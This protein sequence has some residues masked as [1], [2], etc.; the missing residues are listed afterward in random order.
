MVN[1]AKVKIWGK[2]VGVLMWDKTLGLSSFQYYPSFLKLNIP[3]SPIHLPLSQ[4]Q[5]VYRFQ[6]LRNNS[7]FKG[8]PGLI[9]DSL[10]D[11][12][13]NQ[14]INEWLAKNGRSENSLNPIEQLCFIGKRGMGA[15]EFEPDKLNQEN[16]NFEIELDSLVKVAQKVL[17][18]KNNFQRNWK[19]E[20]EEA[21]I[22]LLKVGTSAGGA[23][24]KAII[25]WNKKTNQIKSGQASTEEG[26]EHWILKL[27]G[28]SDVQ[29]GSS[30][31][32]GRI[33]MAYY[34]MAKAAGINI[35]ESRLLEENGRAHFMTKR[36]DRSEKGEKWHIQT[37]CGMQHF[38]FNEVTRYSYEQLFATMRLLKLSYPE[39]QEQFRRMVFNVLAKNCDDHTK[40]FAFRLKPNQAWELAPAYDVCFSYRP[41][42]NWVSQHALSINGKREH[43]YESD[44]MAL[45]NKINIKSNVAKSIIEEV[46]KAVSDW[47][48]FAVELAVEK[49]KQKAISK[50]LNDTN[51]VFEAS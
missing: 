20:E 44:M 14:L 6:E 34:L 47:N 35:M 15:L 48:K 17:N 30:E 39:A 12:Y 45:A 10:P 27:D 51:K 1:A 38:D 46:R 40:N 33:E 7:T 13:G 8:L 29:F 22:D 31:G 43:F 41:G 19:N 49:E 21:L 25:S 5:K 2:D 9:A 3:L 4:G 50:I 16:Q 11:K 24:P 18:Q 36:F 32:Y 23:R 26:Y 42:S 28:V 37:F